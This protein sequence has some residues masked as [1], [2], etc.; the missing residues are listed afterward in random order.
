MKHASVLLVT[1]AL[2]IVGIAGSL[3]QESYS[4][5]YQFQPGA[6]YLYADTARS[7]QTQEMMGQEMK[8]ASLTTMRTRIVC[9][10]VQAEGAMTL[11]TSL[12]SMTVAMKS[13]MRDTTMVMTDLLGK[14]TRMTLT[15]GGVVLNREIVDSLKATGMMV[16]GM[17]MREGVKFHRLSKDPVSVGGSWKSDALDSTEMMGGKMV[18]HIKMDYTVSGKGVCQGRACLQIGYKGEIGIEGKGSMMG[19]DLFMEG[20]GKTSGTLFFDPKDGVL[21]QEAASTDTEMTAAVTGQQNMTIPISSALKTTRT[22][23]SVEGANK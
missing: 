16:R 17:S 11:I 5:T 9:E 2:V 15:P 6:T 14:R 20:K 4:L 1:A 3:A 23:L 19:M 18:S 7:N 10:G 22:L 12:D 8:I 21:V 13:P